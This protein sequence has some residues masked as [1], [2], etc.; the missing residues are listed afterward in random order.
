ML[1]WT[2]PYTVKSERPDCVLQ[3]SQ[4]EDAANQED[5]AERTLGP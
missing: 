3:S 2:L 1:M 4:K 5:D